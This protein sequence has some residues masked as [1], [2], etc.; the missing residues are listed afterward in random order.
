MTI[1]VGEVVATFVKPRKGHPVAP[2]PYLECREG[3]GIVGDANADPRSPRQVLLMAAEV[4]AGFGLEQG[5]L[6]ENVTTSGVDVDRLGSGTLLQ[7]GT[8][9]VL[10]V[11]CA[12]RPCSV[13]TAATGVAVRR[14]VGRRGMLATVVHG[15]PV[16]PGDP[17]RV[18]PERLP[19]LP[20]S[21]LDRLRLVVAGIP[22]GT[23]LSAGEVITAVG[24]P[25]TLRRLLPR[26]LVQLEA[27]GLPAHRVVA[28]AEPA[29][30][31]AVP[32]P[33]GNPAGA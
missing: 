22:A 27:E 18:L 5:A 4:A 12:C 32:R 28:P 7:F 21:Y 13:M 10:G 2:A 9:A 20:D 14:L 1:A 31:P 6:W 29:G 15:G 3:F 19:P 30:G 8:T 16:A 26:W 24:G 33:P 11:T 23:V 25:S 17:I